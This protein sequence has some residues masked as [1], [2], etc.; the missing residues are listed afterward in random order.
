MI[1]LSLSHYLENRTTLLSFHN[2]RCVF[3]FTFS[4][5][6]SD[7][8]NTSG[9][10]KNDIRRKSGVG[11]RFCVLSRF[12]HL[13][14]VAA[15]PAQCLNDVLPPIMLSF[16]FL[17]HLPVYLR[18]NVVI[19]LYEYMVCILFV[20]CVPIRAFLYVSVRVCV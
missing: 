20:S 1:C 9:G 7:A 3:F 2:L 6:V 14:L 13:L 16:L 11:V 5:T 8:A 18:P 17:P 12:V 19:F 15:N 10:R 4:N